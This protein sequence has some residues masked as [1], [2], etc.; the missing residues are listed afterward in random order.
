M[1]LIISMA[2]INWLNFLLCIVHANIAFAPNPKDSNNELFADAESAL[3]S[4]YAQFVEQSKQHKPVYFSDNQ[5]T[6]ETI[7]LESIPNPETETA[8]PMFIC[9]FLGCMKKM[10]SVEEYLEHFKMHEKQGY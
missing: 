9:G 6:L 3:G 5:N 4:E 1:V 8:Y 7:K 10:N 2:R